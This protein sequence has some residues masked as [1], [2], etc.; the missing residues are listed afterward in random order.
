MSTHRWRLAMATSIGTSHL[1]NGTPCQ[2]AVAYRLFR[3]HREPILACAVCD[4]AGSAPKSDS[5]AQLASA[6]ILRLVEHYCT[7]MGRLKDVTREIAAQWVGDTAEAVKVLAA[8]NGD[9]VRDYACTLLLAVIGRSS[10]LFVQIGDG[11][12]VVGDESAQEWSWV[13]W[14][15]HG[16]YINQT[17][18]IVSL[19]LLN[20]WNLS[21]RL[22][23]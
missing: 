23:G 10:A 5:G 9:P 11:A 16:D 20:V 8:K 6:T 3:A 7:T 12:I 15:A 14:P 13:F 2:D 21:R 17:V 4:G 18:F 19:M 22:V 1:D